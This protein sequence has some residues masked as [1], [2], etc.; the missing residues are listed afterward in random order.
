MVNI[1]N[2]NTLTITKSE[3]NKSFSGYSGGNLFPL[4]K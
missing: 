2:N 1:N 4:D 3:F